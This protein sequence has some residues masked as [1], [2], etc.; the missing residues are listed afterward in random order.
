MKKNI[1]HNFR[2]S[3]PE[4]INKVSSQ[5]PNRQE[6]S[7]KEFSLVKK[8]LRRTGISILIFIAAITA[9]YFIKIKTD[10]F[11]VLLSKIGRW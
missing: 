6:P 8:D 11:T 2:H 9:I 5:N 4:I 10:W 3:D 7:K 1:K